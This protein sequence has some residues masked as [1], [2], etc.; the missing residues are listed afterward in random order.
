VGIWLVDDVGKLQ[1]RARLEGLQWVFETPA[2]GHAETWQ[3]RFTVDYFDKVVPIGSSQ[4][5]GHWWALS[6]RGRD[7]TALVEIDLTSGSERVEHADAEVDISSVLW[8]RK[9]QRPLAVST[10]PDVQRWHAFDPAVRQALQKLQ[11]ANAETKDA[12]SLVLAQQP[13]IQFGQL[14]GDERWLNATVLRH[15]GGEHLLYDLQEQRFEVLGQLGRSRIAKDIAL[16]PQQPIRFKSRDGLTLNG[17]LIEPIGV[18][19]PY[20][21]V[22]QV[23]GGPWTRDVHNDG[24]PMLAFLSNRGYAVLQV[25][26]RG[27]GGYG[28]AFMEAAKG[29]FARKMHSDLTDAVDALVAQGVIDPQRLAI[30]GGSYGGYASL[31]G[32]T[33]TPG[34]F[35]CAISLVGMSD[36]AS[37]LSD[38]P[39][40]WAL[41]KPHWTAY[42]GD[43][44][45]ADQRADMKSR[46]PL[47]F[48]DKVQG[49][50]LL[51]H[52]T[53]DPRVKVDQ[54]ERMAEALRRHGKPVELVLFDKAGHGSERWQDTLIG[55]RKA[56]DF[57]ATCLGG[58]S[59]GF[60]FFEL[61][62]K[63][64]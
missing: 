30:A 16:P 35:R 15:D 20:P 23:H 14:N 21:T 26:Y 33:H 9:R 34:K 47:Y 13:R 7:K 40:Y 29:E 19:K 6:N 22:I 64:F 11:A 28:K 4:K 39:A 25:N 56:E 18:P 8:S 17:Y 12:A 31:V 46:S 55:M 41:S 45:S 2:I 57:L 1:G 32:M 42:V 62:A 63:L 36:L 50:I 54:S 59:R 48:A 53:H 10:D 3:R 38:S 51:M 61:G 52:G 27:S 37:L 60:D 58:R 49:P 5:Q 43:P 24:S 44:S